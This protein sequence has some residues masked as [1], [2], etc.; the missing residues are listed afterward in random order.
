VT[1][2]ALAMIE[3][4]EALVRSLGFKV[5]RVRHLALSGETRA[6]VQVAPAEMDRI[7]PMTGALI[8]GLRAAG[9]DSVEIDPQG[10]RSTAPREPQK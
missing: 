4:G 1:T 10:Y 6:R 5:F 8:S 9:Y 3:R 7:A 2:G